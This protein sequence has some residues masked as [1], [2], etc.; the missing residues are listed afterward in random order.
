MIKLFL[1]TPMYGGMC[2]GHYTQ[3]LL[4]LQ[5]LAQTSNIVLATS[6]MFNESLIQRGRNA[7]A[8]NF[9]KTDFTHL[10]FIDADIVFNPADILSMLMADKDIICG[11]YPKKEINWT[12][13][14]RAARAG[15]PPEELKFYSGSHVINL[16]DNASEACF[17]VDQ[18]AEILNGG[19]GFMLIKRKVL[20]TL[21]PHV[22]KYSN[23][24]LDLSGGMQLAEPIYEFFGTSICENTG[25]LLSEDYEFCRKW[26]ATGGKIWA[27]PWIRLA[28]VGTYNFDGHLSPALPD[29]LEGV[30]TA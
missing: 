14:A 17:P 22:G 28:H 8:H 30:K 10:L 24:T 26:R 12:A 9:L 3:S 29:Q 1:A 23:N 25:V 20:E 15:V 18:P 19:T 16:L 6:F 2:T 7:L 11:V 13:V 27:A 21:I 5:N 4:Q